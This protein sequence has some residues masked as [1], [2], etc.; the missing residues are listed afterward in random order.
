MAPITGAVRDASSGS[1]KA[2]K[3]VNAVSE[4]GAVGMDHN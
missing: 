1:G 2:G 3:P 4:Q